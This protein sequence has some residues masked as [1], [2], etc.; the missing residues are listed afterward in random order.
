MTDAGGAVRTLTIP[1]S[2]AWTRSQLSGLHLAAGPA[3]ATV[4]VRAASG[5]GYLFV[6]G[7]GFVNTV[8]EP[9]RGARPRR[10]H[11]VDSLCSACRGTW[12]MSR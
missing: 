3:T 9:C 7:L 11:A 2:S 8:S 4:T 10:R 5:N 1:A 6:D 12:V